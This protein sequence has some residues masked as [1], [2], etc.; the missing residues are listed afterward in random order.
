[1]KQI[2]CSGSYCPSNKESM[3]KFLILRFVSL[4]YVMPSMKIKSQLSQGICI[5][6][7]EMKLDGYA[8]CIY[9]TSDSKTYI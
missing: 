1:M 7:T 4:G 3:V 6:K 5:L 8:L 2:I 9:N